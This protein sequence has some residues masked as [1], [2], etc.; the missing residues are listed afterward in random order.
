[1]L[2]KFSSLIIT[3]ALAFSI[4]IVPPSDPINPNNESF[5]VTSGNSGV[6]LPW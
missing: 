1:M 5:V 3:T 2:K 4:M 6:I